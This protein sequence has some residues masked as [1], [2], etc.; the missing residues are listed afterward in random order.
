MAEAAQRIDAPQG[1]AD[2][3]VVGRLGAAH[4][5]RGWL[6]VSSFTDPPDNLLSYRPW[7]LQAGGAW[8]EAQVEATERHGDGFL[9]RFAGVADRT[10]AAALRG[11]LVA[12]PGAALPPLDDGEYYWRDLIGLDLVNVRGAA[13]GRV[14][15]LMETGAN[16]ALIAHDGELQRLVP[17]VAHVVRNVDLARR[18]I[19]VDWE[20][21]F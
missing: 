5:V 8:R 13:L 6:R 19:V 12:V 9:C 21:D 3:V 14:A 2:L 17:F 7:S 15:N 16:H 1:D 11:A 20:A 4:G 10:A 18:V